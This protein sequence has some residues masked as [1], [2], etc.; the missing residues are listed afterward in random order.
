M[1]LRISKGCTQLRVR[2]RLQ[3]D[4]VLLI[5]FGEGIA[6]IYTEMQLSEY[7]IIINSLKK[8]NI[9]IKK[10]IFIVFL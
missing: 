6:G 3:F 2:A 10:N 4:K 5:N 9:V 1:V 7:L 8:S